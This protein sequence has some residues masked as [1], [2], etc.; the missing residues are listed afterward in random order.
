MDGFCVA[1]NFQT[2]KCPNKVSKTGWLI[3]TATEIIPS[4]LVLS[5]LFFNVNLQSG[6]VSCIIL[7]FQFY[8]SLN[9]Y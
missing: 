5:I 3:Y 7:F 9:I 8:S 2:F 1:I 4:I 6:A